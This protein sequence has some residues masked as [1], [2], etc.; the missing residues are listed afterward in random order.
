MH[1]QVVNVGSGSY[2]KTFPGVDAAGRNGYPSGT[3]F[4]TGNA[5]SKPI[6]T[7][8]WWSHK[9]KNSHSS[10][11]FNYPF[12]L[13]TKNEGLLVSY[14][15]WGPLDAFEP[16]V[17]G[18]SNLNAAAA[19]VSDFTD[20][21]VTM[22]WDSGSN[23]F[24]ATSGIGMP[25]LYFTKDSNSL[26]QVNINQGTVSVTNEMIV[27]T[28]AHF[29]ADFAIYAPTGSTWIKSG[30][31]Y[32]ST[33]NGE[34]YWSLAFLPPNASSVPVVAA[35]FKK[36]AYVFPQNT[37]TSWNYSETTGN[38]TTHFNIITDVKEGTDSTMLMGLLP[39]HWSNL[40]NTPTFTS[41]EY[42]T[43][44]GVLKTIE[45]NSFTVQNKFHGILPTLPFLGYLDSTFSPADL[46]SK[47]K[48][49]QNDALNPWTD[50]YNEG[51]EMNRLIQTARIAELTGDTVAFQSLFTTVKTRLED[52]LKVQANEVAF[53]FYYNQTWTAL[54]GYPAGHGQDVNI[55]DHH[56]HWGYFIHA[57][58][59]MEQFEPGWASQ[60]GGMV[61][62]LVRDAASPDRND[63]LFPFLRNFSPY[64][65]H[66]WANGFASFPHGNDQESTSESMQFNSSLIHWGS[67]TGND[68]IRDL[69]I[70]LYTT[71]QSAVEEY[72]FDK[73]NRNFSP[74]HP[75]SL[76]S[77]VWGNSYDN[78]T[79]WTSDIAASYGI[80]L[81]PIH[82]GSL[83]LGHDTTYVNMLWA[84]MEQNTGILNNDPNVNLWHDTYWK[85]LAFT[86]PAKALNLYHSY[87][88]RNL[89]FG[90]SDAHTYYWLYSM[91]A[92]GV[93][94]TSILA[95]HPL[96]VV[97]N[98]N[99][100]LTY[101]AQNYS[102]D[103]IVVNY[104]DGFALSVPP[105]TLATSKDIDLK[106]TL[107][108]SFPQAYPNG[109]VDLSVLVT[110]GT[111]S[112]IAFYD[113]DSLIGTSN[114]MPYT[115]PANNLSVGRHQFHARVYDGINFNITNIVTVIVGE[116]LPY[117]GIPFSIPGSFDAAHYDIFEGGRG[118]DICYQ[119][120]TNN[121]QGDFR[122]NEYVDAVST[123]TEGDVIG[124]ISSGEWVE[125]HIDVQQAGNY[126][127]SLRYACGNN[128]GGGP[129]KLLSDGVEIKSGITFTY[130]GNWNNWVTKNV[131]NIPLKSGKQI[132][133]IY[134][135]QGEINLGKLT[136]SYSSPLNYSQPI[137][138][139]G[140]N[141][142]VVLP[143]SITSLD[144]SNSID[145]NGS[146]LSYKWEQV[147]GPTILNFVND[148]A[149]QPLISNL[150]NGV[151]LVRLMVTN[152]SYSDQ[153]EVY[154]VS[155]TSNNAPPK[156]SIFTPVDNS[157]F[158][159]GENVDFTVFASDLNDSISSV[160]LYAN[161]TKIHSFG[162]APYHW[163]WQ[164]SAGN[165]IVYAV[166]FD[167]FGDS[168]ISSSTSIEIEP[169]P[170]CRGTSWNGDFDFEFSPDDNNPTIT[171]IPSQAGV[172]NPTCILYYGT[173]PGNMPGYIV[174]PNVPFQLNATKGSKVYFYYTYS[175]PGSGERNNSANKDSYVVGTC[176]TINIE[177]FN[178]NTIKVYPNPVSD[179]LHLEFPDKNAIVNV[180][181]LNGKLID[182]FT[183]DDLSM[184][185][186]VSSL[187]SGIYIFKVLLQNEFYAIKVIKE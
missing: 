60:W 23:H 92:L 119:D 150:S 7:N 40:S 54:L 36:Y 168:T 35:Q 26:A 182:H 135:D 8:D 101:V 84:E 107:S 134:F 67:V 49:L 167:S 96:A 159:E 132:L 118:N 128:A 161:S 12:T 127:L 112:S 20:W 111:A 97:F 47:V 6:P 25:F 116:Q 55:N 130:T 83:Y 141:Q 30:N 52:W 148:T 163:T 48:L 63:S 106:G 129:L 73:H 181:S 140:A 21:T 154:I 102:N 103:S 62:L 186:D 71:E 136:F 105:N 82:G 46:S 121:N 175:Y 153:D 187:K 160:Q 53:L 2:T 142:V 43:V 29:G 146:T 9:V 77:R 100:D 28:N 65:G 88:Q 37:E 123:T 81:Y 166:A 115:I 34:N 157:T 39:H 74:T 117:S 3:P 155:N 143:Q 164:P 156:V 85:Y 27:V 69:G 64:A 120:H 147:Y 58:A 87:P 176:K 24:S 104:S 185:Y 94:D 80:E 145:P 183:C 172:G 56:F 178:L 162:Q 15:P 170:S 180:Y 109:S 57:A 138:D 110:G 149:Q 133:R 19:N 99:G 91:S 5:S 114:Q 151:Y 38:V 22:D 70:Y 152:G 177:E 32:T 75:Y 76:V 72:W 79:F 44:R 45:S 98:K 78:G 113:G 4:V 59:F 144:G 126:D 68:S 31:V 1:G 16:I 165:H 137:A 108:S 86:D 33:L 51:Q 184:E 13:S 179:L 66:C 18:V 124:W 42:P 173:D 131:S 89:K 90:I 122:I 171:F 93:V 10:N 139:A 41:Y 17:V 14:I 158:F 11:L 95:D 125:Y 169:A 50:S 61:D 174:T